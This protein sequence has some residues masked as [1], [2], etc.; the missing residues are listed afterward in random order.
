MPYKTDWLVDEKN[1]IPGAF[2]RQPNRFTTPFGT[3]HGELPVERGRY[4]L[5]WSAACPWA[6]RQMIARGLLGLEDAMSVGLVDPVRPRPN[7]E[8]VRPIPG[9]VDMPEDLRG[10]RL[11]WA[12]TLDRD[13]RDP[14]LGVKYLSDLYLN[15]NPEYSGRF[16]VPAVVDIP[17]GKVVNNDYFNL[18]YYW[19]TVW[20]PFHKEGA[21][22]L[23][24]EKL[25]EKINALNEVI[26]HEINNG[27]Y[28][29]GFARSQAAYEDAFALVF[30]RLDWLD[31]RLS[32]SRYLFGSALTD[33]DIR[34]YVTL[35]RFDFAYYNAFRLNRHLLRDFP[36]LW[37]YTRDLYQIPAFGE[38][39]LF[40]HIKKH[41]HICCDPGN[42]F[43]IVPAGPDEAIFN[44]PHGRGRIHEEAVG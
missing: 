17:S 33:S 27:V 7:A 28:K 14:V 8:G 19:E 25:R 23:Y 21:P 36:N 39:T 13:K 24:P 31:G 12:F 11:D 44:T 4:R 2:I 1:N 40:D 18:T 15:T 42:S 6:T 22:D 9:K 20:K 34:L 3:G 35:V 16:T 37:G 29:A 5:I 41:Y 10:F 32:E 26:F 30:K 43:G 38:N